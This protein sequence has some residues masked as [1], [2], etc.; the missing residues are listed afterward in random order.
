MTTLFGPLGPRLSWT[1]LSRLL[2]FL[3]AAALVAVCVGWVYSALLLPLLIGAFLAYLLLPFV[4]KL[5]RH[6]IP[7]GPAVLTLVAGSLALLAFAAV[8]IAPVLYHQVLL[9]IRLIPGAYNTVVQSWLPIVEKYV[10]GLGVGSQG[11]VHRFLG[12]SAVLGHFE[13]QLESSL[14]SLWATGTS[15]AGGMLNLLLVPVFTF[16]LLKDHVKI[17]RALHRLVPRDLL[18]P[19]DRLMHQMSLTL[20]SVL[21]GQAT[22]A[23]ILGILY[24]IGLSLVGLQSAV[25]IGV[26]AGICR[27]VPYLDVIVGGILSAIVLL[28][29]FAGWGQ[30]VSVVLVFL[31]VQTIDGALVTPTV[32]RQRVGLHPLL[33]I[34]SV[35][36]FGSWFGFWGVLIAIPLVAVGKVLINAVLPYYYSSATYAGVGEELGSPLESATP[37]PRTD[38]AAAG[39][40]D[41]GA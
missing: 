3:G 18:G 26:V 5:E 8:R 2:W 30:V 16:F 13:S 24:V 31:V 23:G 27:V 32:I 41:G 33:V 29:N 37:L 35:I 40:G 9:I 15:V 11:E 25:A 14:T 19:V 34:V 4:A 7:R 17:P 21:K 36:A 10:A 28:S 39:K 20:R 38:T 22:V 12:G 6:G 1:R